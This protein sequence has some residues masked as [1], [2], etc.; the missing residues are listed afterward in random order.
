MRGICLLLILNSM[1]IFGADFSMSN[2]FYRKKQKKLTF[3]DVF[4]GSTWVPL[5]EKEKI[6]ILRGSQW[7]EI[8]TF[9]S[10]NLTNETILYKEGSSS[11]E[12]ILPSLVFVKRLEISV[13]GQRFSSGGII[14]AKHVEGNFYFLY[15]FA[16]VQKE[17]TSP[18]IVYGFYRTADGITHSAPIRELIG[19]TEKK[20]PFL[21]SMKLK[22]VL[23]E[24]DVEVR[25]GEG[26]KRALLPQSYERRS[27]FRKLFFCCS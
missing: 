3:C 2:D 18:R 9:F 13:N 27:L 16:Q 12:E 21:K 7:N 26:E 22:K 23:Q 8:G 19:F 5:R 20:S 11:L 25:R 17:G 4:K 1:T 15:A 14:N 24:Q 10:W 6:F